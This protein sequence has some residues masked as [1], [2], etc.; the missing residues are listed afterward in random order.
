[1]NRSRLPH[2]YVVDDDAHIRESL[3]TLITG[4]GYAVD[5]FASAEN[6]LERAELEA[7]ACLL[8]DVHLK[9]MGGIDLQE[10]LIC[11][12]SR[13]SIVAMSGYDEIDVAV[14]AMRMGAADFIEKPFQP[15]DLLERLKAATEALVHVEASRRLSRQSAMLLSTLTTREQEVVT[16]LV[17]GKP[18]KVIANELDV[19][20]RTVE[21]H[22]IHIMQKLGVDSLAHLVRL[23][24][25]A[26]HA[27]ALSTTEPGAP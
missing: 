3:K 25:S 20:P 4:A 22:R 14:K 6:F 18:N 24:L 19:S 7:P 16:K 26:Q 23:W 13:A 21:T 5:C 15:D 8:I 11:D 27:Q 9:G 12:G 2:V 17:D 1:M 10:R